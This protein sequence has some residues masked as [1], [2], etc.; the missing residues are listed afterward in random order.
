MI[1]TSWQIINKI[2][3]KSETHTTPYVPMKQTLPERY[4]P[5]PTAVPQEGFPKQPRD[6]A[7]VSMLAKVW[8]VLSLVVV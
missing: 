8:V 4:V 2:K 5:E 3:K 7:R 1:I 6:D